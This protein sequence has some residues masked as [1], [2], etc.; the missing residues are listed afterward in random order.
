MRLIILY[1]RDNEPFDFIIFYVTIQDAGT[2]IF[3]GLLRI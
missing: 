3:K 2:T 1:I